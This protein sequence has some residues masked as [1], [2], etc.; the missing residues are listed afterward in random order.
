MQGELSA[1]TYTVETT[2]EP[3]GG[4]SLLA[5]RHVSTTIF[6]ASREFGP[7]SR[8]VV[9]IE[10]LDLDGALKRDAA[11]G[12]YQSVR[13]VL[14]RRDVVASLQDRAGAAGAHE[15]QAAAAIR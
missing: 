8:Q 13:T 7:A 11:R 3:V 4:L 6:L 1:G 12:G 10:P 5:Y 9:T 14:T 15:R 2:E